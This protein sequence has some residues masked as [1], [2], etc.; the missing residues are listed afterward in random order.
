MRSI[1]SA[2][3]KIIQPN[4]LILR[5]NGYTSLPTGCVT[6]TVI[7]TQS[8]DAESPRDLLRTKTLGG[9]A[10]PSRRSSP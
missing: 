3:F 8:S 2:R 6:G 10:S 7:A 1:G 9:R 5:A 4:H